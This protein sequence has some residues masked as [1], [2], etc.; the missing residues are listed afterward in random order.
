M[1]K[2]E[3]RLERATCRKLVRLCKRQYTVSEAVAKYDRAHSHYQKLVRTGDGGESSGA[4]IADTV[5][6]INALARYCRMRG[7]A[8]KE[9]R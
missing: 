8:L 6:Y 3:E 5:A 4:L 1:T 7:V 2:H 9:I